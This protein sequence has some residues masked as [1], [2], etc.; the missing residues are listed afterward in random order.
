MSLKRSL[1]ALVMKSASILLTINSKFCTLIIAPI[2]TVIFW[3]PPLISI[4]L[5]DKKCTVC[6]HMN[7]CL[8]NLFTRVAVR[9]SRTC[10][11]RSCVN[12][13]SHVLVKNFVKILL[14]PKTFFWTL[15]LVTTFETK[16]YSNQDQQA[17]Y[18]NKM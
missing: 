17:M 6:L 12:K 8:H 1:L 2:I 7:I 18:E 14:K 3:S 13:V 10:Y 16:K 11:H 4:F 5:I 15:V 9:E